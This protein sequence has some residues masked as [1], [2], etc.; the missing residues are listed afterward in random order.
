MIVWSRRAPMFSIAS[1]TSAAV[2]AISRIEASVNRSFTPSVS[3]SA[4]YC[5]VS[6]FR[7]SVRMRSKS[8]AVRLRS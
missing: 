6:A 2:R 8:S 7:G 4:W 5:S 3:S 1:F